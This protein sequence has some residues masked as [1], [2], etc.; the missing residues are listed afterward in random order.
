[1]DREVHSFFLEE[2]NVRDRLRS[3]TGGA[4][5]TMAASLEA[6]GLQTP[7][8]LRVEEDDAG[9]HLFLVAGA[10]RLAA[11]SKL[12]WKRID[13]V[14]LEGTAD[15][16]RLWEIA[17]N[18]HR[19]ELTVQERAD[20]IAEWVRLSEARKGAQ[21]APPGGQQ[22]HEAGIKA[23]VRSLGIERT[24]VQ[25]AAKIA[26]IAPEAKVAARE[27]GLDDNQSALLKIAREP[28]G[29]QAAKVSELAARSIRKPVAIPDAPL[30]EEDRINRDH[31]AVLRLFERTHRVALERARVD[32]DSILD[33][34]VFDQTAAGRAVA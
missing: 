14:I 4:I 17:E 7:I 2:I 26:S 27:A 30:N 22:P 3:V 12:G 20:H 16:A 1:V 5:E 28:A 15:D 25:R 18:L 9:E 10:T 8:T 33:G 32:L 29:K 19:A 11:A 34:P 21:L 24:Q 31:A 6:L 23:A 13:C